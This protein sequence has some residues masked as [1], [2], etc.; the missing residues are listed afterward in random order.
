MESLY[1]EAATVMAIEVD[2]GGW[3][4]TSS[5]H[6]DEYGDGRASQEIKSNELSSWIV[7]SQEYDIYI[8]CISSRAG[9]EE[10]PNKHM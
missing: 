4:V 10:M 2:V 9:R 1:E 5:D 6:M 8:N 7:P 3:N